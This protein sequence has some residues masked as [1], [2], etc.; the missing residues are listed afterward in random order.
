MEEYVANSLR[1]IEPPD[2]SDTVAT[3]D[4]DLATLLEPVQWGLRMHSREQRNV[5]IPISFCPVGYIDVD[6]DGQVVEVDENACSLLGVGRE[7]LLSR[8]ILDYVTPTDREECAAHLAQIASGM[9]PALVELRLGAIEK[10]SIPLV[11][12]VRMEIAAQ[13]EPGRIR[14]TVGTETGRIYQNAMP[15]H[16]VH[17]L[18][19]LMECSRDGIS[20]TDENGYVI[21]WNHAMELITGLRNHEVM[22]RTIWDIRAE[23]AP[24][25]EK[26]DESSANFGDLLADM[27]RRRSSLQLHIPRELV[28]QHQASG[29]MHTIQVSDYRIPTAKGFLFGSIHRD[30]TESRITAERLR[31]SKADLA[32]LSLAGQAFTSSL[33]LEQVLQTVLNEVTLLLDVTEAYFWVM[34]DT[35]MGMVCSLAVDSNGKTLSPLST[36]YGSRLAKWIRHKGDSLVIADL[37]SEVPQSDRVFTVAHTGMRSCMF[38]PLRSKGGVVGALHLLDER[39][40]QFTSGDLELIT[41]LASSAAVAVENVMLYKQA[42]TLATVEARQQLA[43][44]LHDGVNQS[45]FSAG[46]LAEVLPRLWELDPEQGRQSLSDL[47]WL[48]RGAIAELREVLTELRPLESD[49]VA[50]EVRLRQLGDIVAGRTGIPVKF[51]SFGEDELPSKVQTVLYRLCREALSNIAKHAHASHID[52]HM[53]NEDGVLELYIRDDGDGFDPDLT[54]DGHDGLRM[55]RERAVIIGA[56]LSITSQPL[57]GTEITIRWVAKEK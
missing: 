5:S 30:T 2:I 10:Q 34:D 4:G 37:T 11:L 56:D 41:A 40:S 15:E 28:I 50:L 31:R 38:V 6:I 8:S 25:P 18:M 17:A 39:P 23:I 44:E 36:D 42:Q 52:M 12:I 57:W 43:W 48:I 1:R 9:K 53:R 13:T 55:M 35:N 49:D 16:H 7:H 19:C 29:E 21:I 33:N 3:T 24:Y 54:S 47:H 20:L 46:L 26:R 51:E 14:M 32:L 27:R 22:D 45:L